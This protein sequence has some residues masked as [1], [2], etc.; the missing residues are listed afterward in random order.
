MKPNWRHD[1][2]PHLLID[3]E[4]G[5]N[6]WKCESGYD[7][8]FFADNTSFGDPNNI[9]KAAGCIFAE[10]TCP[11]RIQEKW[12]SNQK[13]E[14]SRQKVEGKPRSPPAI[15]ISMKKGGQEAKQFRVLDSLENT[16]GSTTNDLRMATGFSQ[17]TLAEILGELSEKGHISKLRRKGA[18]Q[19]TESGKD[20]VHLERNISLVGYAA[21]ENSMTFVVDD[22]KSHGNIR[23]AVL[24]FDPMLGNRLMKL[25]NDKKHVQALVELLNI[26]AII[27]CEFAESE[28]TK[29]M[30]MSTSGD[31]RDSLVFC[32]LTMPRSGYPSVHDAIVT[33]GTPPLIIGSMALAALE[34]Q[35]SLRKRLMAADGT[36]VSENQFC[37]PLGDYLAVATKLPQKPSVVRSKGILEYQ[38]ICLRCDQTGKCED[39][40][41]PCRFSGDPLSCDVVTKDLN[42]HLSELTIN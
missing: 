32:V 37:L 5:K 26:S 27:W 1:Q 18:W 17:S 24:R 13:E 14:L 25:H 35:L 19:L 33:Q 11:L 31:S 9:A 2:C 39:S 8:D 4:G 20:S 10:G 23:A 42:L 7:I 29:G 3:T 30:G 12:K 22:R 36:K 40:R 15:L 41:E 16:G 34:R 38:L 6:H 28:G 21:K